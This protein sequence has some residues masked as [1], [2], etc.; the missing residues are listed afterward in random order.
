MLPLCHC[1]NDGG[2][3]HGQNQTDSKNYYKQTRDGRSRRSSE[4]GFWKH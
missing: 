1:E 2:S 4:P 3:N